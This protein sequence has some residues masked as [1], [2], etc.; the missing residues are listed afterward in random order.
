MLILT[1]DMHA[2]AHTL[3]E[4]IKTTY[5]MTPFVW[6]WSMDVASVPYYP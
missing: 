2:K 5:V 3:A 6:M 1:T 4:S